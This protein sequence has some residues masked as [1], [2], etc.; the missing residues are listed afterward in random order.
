MD[1]AVAGDAHETAHAS[2]TFNL[3][4]VIFKAITTCT[5]IIITVTTP[6]VYPI[7]IMDEVILRTGAKLDCCLA[8]SQGRMIRM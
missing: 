8:A 3:M 7:V 1:A 5:T 4:L 6:T 2:S